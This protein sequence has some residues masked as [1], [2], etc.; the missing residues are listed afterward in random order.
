MTVD[1]YQILRTKFLKAFANLP[2]KVKM[3]EVVAVI[4]D[5]PYT[6]IAAAIEVR[7]ES[8]TGQKILKILTELGVL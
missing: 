5:N 6:W 4:D 2:E 3:E 8:N 7:S 1:D